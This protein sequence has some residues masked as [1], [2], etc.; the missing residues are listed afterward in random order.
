M[1]LFPLSHEGCA[2]TGKKNP[3]LTVEVMIFYS[4]YTFYMNIPQ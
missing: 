2:F 1:L 3:T 4:F